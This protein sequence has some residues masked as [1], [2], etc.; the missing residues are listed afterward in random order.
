MYNALFSY[1]KEKDVKYKGNVNLS[2]HSYIKIGGIVDVGVFPNTKDKLIL[3]L[4]YLYSGGYPFFVVGKMSNLLPKDSNYNGVAVFTDEVRDY[5]VDGNIVTVD[6]GAM[7][8]S[9]I[10]RLQ[11]LSLGGLEALFGIPGTVGG[12]IYSNAGAFGSEISDRL[13]SVRVYDVTKNSICSLNKSDLNF[14]YRHSLLKENKHIII[15]DAVFSFLKKNLIQIKEDIR[16]CIDKRKATQP[17]GQPSLGSTFKRCNS[18]PIAKLI[19]DCGLKGYR[20]GDAEISKKHAG[21]IVNRGAA[22]SNDYSNLIAY[23]KDKIFEKYSLSI[24]EEIEYLDF[25]PCNKT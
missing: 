16:A 24:N 11:N 12:M 19:D 9:V 2:L 17:I 6:C 20:I 23:I 5:I 15:L 25:L 18:I 1:L 21:F 14:S 3:V 7:L 22:S 10:R 8:S 4:Q 13:I